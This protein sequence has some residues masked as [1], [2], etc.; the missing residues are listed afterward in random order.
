M[1]EL[2]KQSLVFDFVERE[3]KS[4]LFINPVIKLASPI[5]GFLFPTFTDNAADVN[6]V[7]YA[8]GKPNKP[9]FGFL[10][11]VLNGQP[12]VTADEDKA[13]FEEIVKSV[14]VNRWIRRR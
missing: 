1:T 2:P 4:N 5:G 6:H 13:I 12:I 3:F 7:L 8:A 9:D 10:E 14:V 11:N